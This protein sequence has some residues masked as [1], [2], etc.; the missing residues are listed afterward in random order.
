MRLRSVA[1]NAATSS[2]SGNAAMRASSAVTTPRTCSI[3]ALSILSPRTPSSHRYTGWPTSGP[4]LACTA[5]APRS[6]TR[7]L[8]SIS[9]PY[10]VVL[11]SPA[12]A[13]T[14]SSSSAR[15]TS[16]SRCVAGHARTSGTGVVGSA[17]GPSPTTTVPAA[18]GCA[19]GIVVS[20]T[21]GAGP[22]LSR[23]ASLSSSADVRS[24]TSG[25]CIAAGNA[26]IIPM[27][28]R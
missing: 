19:G 16:D 14:N 25:S 17:A 8:P 9:L 2:P 21:A 1:S 13:S 10:S 12:N 18:A 26:P 23:A 6:I 5:L 24:S 28:D 20:V 15:S 11:S 27:F 7:V 4:T 22:G 3:A